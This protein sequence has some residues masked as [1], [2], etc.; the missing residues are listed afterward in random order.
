[1]LRILFL[2]SNNFA[3]SAA[4]GSTMAGASVATKVAIRGSCLR[5]VAP[6]F[7]TTHLLNEWLA[8]VEAKITFKKRRFL[9]QTTAFEVAS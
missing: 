5:I 7:R 3:V 2:S 6:L 8:M 4:F 1:L 9:D